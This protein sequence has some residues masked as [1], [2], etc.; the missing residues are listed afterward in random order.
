LRLFNWKT[1]EE[2]IDDS[3]G[4]AK[5]TITLT[6]EHIHDIE[7]LMRVTGLTTK[8]ELI[9]NALTLFDWAVRK[10]QLGQK[11]TAVDEVKEEN[12]EVV[13]QALENVLSTTGS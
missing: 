13:M 2:P 5:L 9:N 11:I 4:T 10:K 1:H 6:R 3:R 7:E 12:T 8:A